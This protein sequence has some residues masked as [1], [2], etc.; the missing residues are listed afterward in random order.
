MKIIKNNECHSN[1][2]KKLGNLTLGPNFVTGLI[3]VEGYFLILEPKKDRAKFKV[4]VSL[5]YKISM[6]NNE[7]ELLGMVKSFFWF[8]C[9]KAK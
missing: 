5:K 9:S 1:L 4:S 2:P 6:L 7:V 3:D 8:W